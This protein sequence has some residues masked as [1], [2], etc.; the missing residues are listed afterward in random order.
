MSISLSLL[1]KISSLGSLGDC[2]CGSRFCKSGEVDMLG[3]VERGGKHCERWR[4]KN[5]LD[6]NNASRTTAYIPS[7]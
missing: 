6:G 3:V 2:F 4:E 7:Q 5:R 1:S